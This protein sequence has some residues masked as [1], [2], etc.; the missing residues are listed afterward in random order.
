MQ[1]RASKMMEY[2]V[3]CC[4]KKKEKTLRGF[5][6]KYGYKRGSYTLTL[7]IINP[8]KINEEHS[9]RDTKKL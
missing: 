9:N 5:I 4:R 7:S 3:G 6:R 2:G 8:N 1:T